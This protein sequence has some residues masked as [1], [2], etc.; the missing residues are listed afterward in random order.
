M[1]HPRH[2]HSRESALSLCRHYGGDAMIVWLLLFVLWSS[3][4]LAVP[5]ALAGMGRW[6]QTGGPGGGDVRVIAVD[7]KT[8][9]TLYA[10]TYYGGVFKSTDSG[11]NWR[12]VNTGL[13]TNLNVNTLVIDPATPTTLYAG[14]DGGDWGTDGSVLKST[15]GGASWSAVNTGL[16]DL[17]INALVI[18]PITPTTLYAATSNGVFKSI[19]GGANWRVVNTGQILSLAVDPATPALTSPENIHP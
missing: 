3:T 13:T 18:D 8:P 9:A 10:G 17:D 12:S 2:R 5:S 11:T 16:M 6:T 4:M 14:T 19:N 7:P 15:D 1:H